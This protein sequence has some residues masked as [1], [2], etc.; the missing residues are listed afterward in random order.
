MFLCAGK[1][2]FSRN[3]GLS[4]FDVEGSDFAVGAVAGVTNDFAVGGGQLL[5]HAE[6]VQLVK[7]GLGLL[8]SKSSSRTS[9]RKPSCF[10]ISF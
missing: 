3:I 6:A 8:G 7:S 10:M 4:I 9:G 1:V 5:L 2:T